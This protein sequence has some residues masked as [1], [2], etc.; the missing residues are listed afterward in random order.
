[1]VTFDPVGCTDAVTGESFGIVA[2]G[3]FAGGW[4]IDTA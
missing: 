4:V 3:P 2:G 1:M